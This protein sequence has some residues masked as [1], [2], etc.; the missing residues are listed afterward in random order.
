MSDVN[1]VRVNRLNASIKLL[2]HPE[3]A[4]ELADMAFHL[5]HA[6]QEI[7]PKFKELFLEKI[8]NVFGKGNIDFESLY[9]YKK[10]ILVST[11]KCTLAET[12]PYSAY[13]KFKRELTTLVRMRLY[14]IL[15][16]NKAKLVNQYGG[17]NSRK[18][19][20]AQAKEQSSRFFSEILP[21]VSLEAKSLA[22]AYGMLDEL[23][24]HEI[25]ITKFNVEFAGRVVTCV[26]VQAV[27][28]QNK[29]H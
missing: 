12:L 14:E 29:L 19:A 4:D 25:E 21:G 11:E 22:E 16:N 6:V 3:F 24:S 7:H 1:A 15:K 2:Q 5:K 27:P 28:A 23:F 26:K 8:F 10:I 9:H 20:L 18:N 17:E 13:L